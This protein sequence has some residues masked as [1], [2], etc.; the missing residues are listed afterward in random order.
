MEPLR[1]SPVC[2]LQLVPLI[3]DFVTT[4]H[5][6]Q[7]QTSVVIMTSY[8]TIAHKAGTALKPAGVPVVEG[9]G[10]QV[11]PGHPPHWRGGRLR[12][13][14]TWVPGRIC[15]WPSRSVPI[16]CRPPAVGLIPPISVRA[17]TH[18]TVSMWIPAVETTSVTDSFVAHWWHVWLLNLHCFTAAPVVPVGRVARP[19]RRAVVTV[20]TLIVMWMRVVVVGASR[21]VEVFCTSKAVLPR[22][23]PVLPWIVAVTGKVPVVLPVPCV[24]IPWAW[25][26]PWARVVSEGCWSLVGGGARVAARPVA[27]LGVVG[28]AVGG[29]TPVVRV[30]WHP[31]GWGCHASSTRL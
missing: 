9:R 16:I 21:L 7:P 29:T 15:P 1:G 19:P 6:R 17:V 4:A 25:S 5:E 27:Q 13:V 12:V 2:Q 26:P 8:T 24:R 20:A 18:L 3:I 10:A 30:P 11:L 23:L 31:P 22:V 28:V 14:I